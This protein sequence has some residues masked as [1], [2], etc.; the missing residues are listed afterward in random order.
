MT[1]TRKAILQLMEEIDDDDAMLS[2]LLHLRDRE[3]RKSLEVLVDTS[4]LMR[5]IVRRIIGAAQPPSS[6]DNDKRT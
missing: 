4:P 1:A 2:L 6:P 5:H 3:I